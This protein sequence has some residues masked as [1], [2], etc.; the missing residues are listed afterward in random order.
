MYFFVLLVAY[1]A[2]EGS[3]LV[4]VAGH[5][6][7]LAAL[8]LIFLVSMGG[9]YLVRRQGAQALVRIQAA[10][11]RNEPPDAELIDGAFIFVAGLLLF[12]PGFL[13]DIVGIILLI[14]PLRGL[15]SPWLVKHLQTRVQRGAY[16]KTYTVYDY[17]WRENAQSGPAENVKQDNATKGPLVIDLPTQETPKKQ[18]KDDP[19]DSSP[20]PG[21]GFNL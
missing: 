21:K 17:E 1:L 11:A 8:A 10:L 18:Q 6:G 9:A 2:A 19:K 5:I 4:F 20:R 14:P 13:S 3:A 15:L 12:L 7:W 16:I